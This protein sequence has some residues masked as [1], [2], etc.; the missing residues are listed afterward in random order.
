MEELLGVH[1]LS[2][3][4]RFP[5]G[6]VNVSSAL[7]KDSLS[8]TD[9]SFMQSINAPKPRACTFGVKPQTLV[10][11]ADLTWRPASRLRPGN[12]VAGFDENPGSSRYGGYGV[13]TVVALAIR[14]ARTLTLGTEF[15]EVTCTT[16]HR[17]LERNRFRSTATIRE[18]RLATVPVLPPAFGA[19]YKMGYLHG[20]LAGD[21]NFTH[22]PAQTRATLRVCDQKFAARFAQYGQDLGFEGFRTFT[23]IAGYTKR[24]LYGVRTSR[25]REAS[26]LGPY[27]EP[28]PPAE[29]MRG[30]LAGAFDAA[31]SRGGGPMVRIHQRISTPPFWQ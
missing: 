27:S 14:T 11:M 23:Y 21:G 24:P 1:V 9:Y 30:G 18:L 20:A 28:S 16:D 10:L 29:N 3:R 12:R 15:G 25:V 17:W 4:G 31:G 6:E 22:G 13:A 2:T 5:T 7:G 26:G 19:D 8:D